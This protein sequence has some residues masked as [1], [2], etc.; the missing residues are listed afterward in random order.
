MENDNSPWEGLCNSTSMVGKR[1]KE[2]KAKF[3]PQCAVSLCFYMWSNPV[4]SW[5]RISTPCCLLLALWCRPKRVQGRV[6][7]RKGSLCSLFCNPP[8]KLT[9]LGTSQK[10]WKKNKP[11]QGLIGFQFAN[12]GKGL[13][14]R[15][16]E[17]L[18]RK[19][20]LMLNPDYRTRPMNSGCH[21]QK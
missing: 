9:S 18:R 4:A 15:T 11:F 12:S 3:L 20:K 6:L 10:A 1:V 19:S 2:S 13:S 16:L 5:T 21:L 17:R 14:T 7:C 8:K